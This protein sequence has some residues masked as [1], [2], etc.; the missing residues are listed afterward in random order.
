MMDENGLRVLVVA[1][2]YK[3]PDDLRELVPALV[4]QVRAVEDDARVLVVDNDPDASAAELVESL[5]SDGIVDYAHAPV[6]GIASARNVALTRAADYDVVVFIDDDERPVSGWLRLLIDT[7]KEHRS[8][9]VVGPVVSRYAIDPDPW[10]TA[11]RFFD[12][13]RLPTG[14]S[15]DLAATNNLL[16]DVRQIRALGL[17]FDERFGLSGGSDTL[18]T[19][20]LHARGG[21]MIWC[22]EAL[23]L[24]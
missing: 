17:A 14:T 24:D 16:L 5:S 9:A 6:P 19:R 18:F 12:R 11:G 21:T 20:Q 4:E 13:R 1:L 10:I 3:R 2:T 23:V 8:A 22:D 15:V 7:Y